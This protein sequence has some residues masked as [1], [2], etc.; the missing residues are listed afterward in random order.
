MAKDIL[1]QIWVAH[2]SD[3]ARVDSEEESELFSKVLLLNIGPGFCGHPQFLRI[4]LLSTIKN[5]YKYI[6]QL[7][8][9]SHKRFNLCVVECAIM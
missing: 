9:T 5:S 4:G 2:W 1:V 8:N 3:P 7:G 6:G